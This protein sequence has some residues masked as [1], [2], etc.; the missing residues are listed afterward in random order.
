MILFL[1]RSLGITTSSPRTEN[2]FYNVATKY[3]IESITLVD[4]SDFTYTIVTHA[5]NNFRLGDKVTI[6]DTLGNTKDSTV[7][8]VISDYSF[9][10]KG[11]GIIVAAKYTVQRKILRGK[12]KTSLTDYSYID[13]YFANVQ[14]T[15]VKFNQDLIV[16][17]SSIPNYD[18]APLDFL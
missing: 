9:S 18:N 17:S 6:T 16:A 7:T 15:Y 1:S 8:E 3:D 11:Q 14:N 5:K 4:S 2:W 13:N 12:V 10:I